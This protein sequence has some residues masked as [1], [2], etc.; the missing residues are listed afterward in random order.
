MSMFDTSLICLECKRLE[1]NRCDYQRAC[2]AELAAIKGGDL[3]F[4][5]IGMKEDG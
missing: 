5:G 3:N 1:R 2:A 4:A